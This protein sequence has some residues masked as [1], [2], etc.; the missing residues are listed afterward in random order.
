MDPII[1]LC[2]KGIF[3][4]KYSS[5]EPSGV[6]S[7]DYFIPT[8]DKMVIFHIIYIKIGSDIFRPTR[9]SAK[10]SVVC[11]NCYYNMCQHVRRGLCVPGVRV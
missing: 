8:L 4:G 11:E 7:Y 6:E 10:R 5:F 9:Y 2:D 3:Y 1:V